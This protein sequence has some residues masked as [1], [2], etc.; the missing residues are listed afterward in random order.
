MPVNMVTFRVQAFIEFEDDD[1]YMSELNALENTLQNFG[2]VD[3]ED[4]TSMDEDESY[5]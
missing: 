3:I 4:E 2:T 5:V 1:D